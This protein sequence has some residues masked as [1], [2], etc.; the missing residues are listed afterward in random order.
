MTLII[1]ESEKKHILGLYGLLE[2]QVKSN[3]PDQKILPT[4]KGK[5]DDYKPTKADFD[6]FKYYDFPPF[7]VKTRSDWVEQASIYLGYQLEVFKYQKGFGSQPCNACSTTI[8]GS[9][10]KD[11]QNKNLC[12]NNNLL[13]KKWKCPE[14]SSFYSV[15]AR[16]YNTV[17]YPKMY[18]LVKTAPKYKDEL[19]RFVEKIRKEGWNFVFD[20]IRESMTSAGGAT[21]QVVVDLLGGGVAV[22]IVWGV[23]LSW[24]AY[25][26]QKGDF[27]II[28]L[29]TDL[30]GVI[31]FGPGGKYLWD[32]FKKSPIPKNATIEMLSSWLQKNPKVIEFFS[33]FNF[34]SALKNTIGKVITFLEKNTIF[35]ELIVSLKSL[36]TKFLSYLEVLSGKTL[37]KVAEKGS[38]SY[39][40]EKGSEEV[41]KR[42]TN[43]ADRT[44]S[45][46]GK[47][48]KLMNKTSKLVKSL[49]PS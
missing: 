2:Q 49:A 42:V 39:A 30:A 8:T 6:I 40:V 32:L 10:S 35:A 27:N 18:N 29:L 33:K 48:I 4:N 1:S 43:L 12:V 17:E 15:M 16:D 38:E 23:L 3:N 46:L 44:S 20:S 24:D 26:S 41:E 5:Y 37:T 21:T 36:Y 34:E 14:G 7:K 31:T 22:E 47:S 25:Q 13:A 11:I 19:D 9:L 28:N 45:E